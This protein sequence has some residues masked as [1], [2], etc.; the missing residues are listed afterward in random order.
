VKKDK[1][2]SLL[3]MY[4]PEMES[5]EDPLCGFRG[6]CRPWKVRKLKCWDFPACKALEQ[7]TGPTEP[8]KSSGI[9][10]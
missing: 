6:S 9:I 4:N 8:W 7:D 2:T 5:V 3:L 1:L 10:K